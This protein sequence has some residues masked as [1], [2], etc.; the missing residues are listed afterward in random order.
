M[1]KSAYNNP[2]HNWNDL[3]DFLD[4][5]NKNKHE[6]VYRGDD[7]SQPLRSKLEKAFNTAGLKSTP[8]KNDAK[9]K[10]SLARGLPN[11]RGQNVSPYLVEGA[12]IRRFKRQ[13]HRYLDHLP[14]DGNYL[15]WMAL[16]RHHG[17]PTRLLDF[18]YSFYMAV[19]FALAEG[20]GKRV[21][22]ALD[23]T[24]NRKDDF[25]SKLKNKSH[26]AWCEWKK[27]EDISNWKTF[28]AIFLRSTPL[29][30]AGV[31]NP[32]RLSERLGLQQGVFL[33]PGDVGKPLQDNLK[34]TIGPLSKNNRIIR[35][36][37]QPTPKDRQDI[38]EHL[39]RMNVNQAT[40][41]PGLDGFARGVTDMLAR[42]WTMTPDENWPVQ[43]PDA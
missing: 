30:I 12:L 27:D 43:R 4:S 9:Y 1:A 13:A 25:S 8:T 38:L 28:N 14:E 5:H 23:T 42:P 18:T 6:W 3:I 16:L 21:V 26:S 33:C 34:E 40:L 35:L 19:Y 11:P 7:D 20:N 24:D 17:G 10:N 2:A 39:G 36:K 29:T 31:V 32:Y 15:E 37:L 41:F 22:W